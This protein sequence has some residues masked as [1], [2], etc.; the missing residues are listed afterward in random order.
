MKKKIYFTRHGE[1][2]DNV[3]M[4]LSTYPPGPNLTVLGR[5]QAEILI[6][7]INKLKISKIYTSPLKR[8]VET[9][10]IINRNLNVEI[11][12]D[13]RI[14]ELLVGDK[15]GRTDSNVFEEM[16]EIWQEWS[17]KNNISLFAGSNGE[18]AEQVLARSKS[19]IN[20]LSEKTNIDNILVI[21]HSGILQL[22][23]G[24]LCENLK[25]I[26][27]YE[28]WIRNC[29]LIETEL[30]NKKLKCIKWGEIII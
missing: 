7:K 29:Q 14:S 26:F 23:L 11:V 4:R 15:E 16:N 28:N 6:P 5:N 19:F 10:E 25:P 20:S 21:A 1:T 27:C 30:C 9:A 18:S 17:L 8:A 13:N 24:H 2:E 3:A 12:K 22:L